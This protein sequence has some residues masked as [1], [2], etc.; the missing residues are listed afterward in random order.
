MQI[1]LCLLG[2]SYFLSRCVSVQ[3]SPVLGV[4]FLTSSVVC[5]YPFQVC[6]R[7]FL[8]VPPSGRDGYQHDVYRRPL[9]KVQVQFE[10]QWLG[11]VPALQ[12]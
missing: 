2:A 9:L 4:T 6:L 12:K 7:C 10:D 1:P 5:S 8:E 3:E 11:T